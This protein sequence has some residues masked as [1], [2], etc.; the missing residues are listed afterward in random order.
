V[1]VKSLCAY[2]RVCLY[3]RTPPLSLTCVSTLNV[4][5][6]VGVWHERETI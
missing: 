2:V 3:V 1:C 4:C 6:D 5:D